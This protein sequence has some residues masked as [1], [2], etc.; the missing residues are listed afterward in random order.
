MTA[1]RQIDPMTTV[2]PE[3]A[4]EM[5][6]RVPIGPG[7]S[8]RPVPS[9]WTVT[10]SGLDRPTMEHVVDLLRQCGLRGTRRLVR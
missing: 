9:G 8:A 5:G 1:G 10:V 2:S 6:L 7:R 4:A 3:E